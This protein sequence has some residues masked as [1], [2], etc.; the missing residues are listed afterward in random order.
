MTDHF[1]KVTELPGEEISQEQLERL[2]HRYYWAA[3]YVRGRD[4]LEVAC[5]AGP[6][7]RYLAQRARTVKAGDVSPE[8]LSR[9]QRHVGQDVELKVFDAQ[10]MPYPDASFDAVIIF[11][12]LYYVPSAQRFLAEAERSL[13]TRR[14]I[15]DIE[16]QS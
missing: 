8:V 4:V 15:A 3:E 16:C 11:E 1:L 7:L 2:C 10:D 9:A 6:G 14:C 13:E 5:G 12:A